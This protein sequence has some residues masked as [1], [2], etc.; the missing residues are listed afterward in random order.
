VSEVRRTGENLPLTEELSAVFARMSGLLL[1]EETVETS[2]GLLSSLAQE[3]VPGSSGAGVSI[4]DE[5][6]KRSS[7]STDARVRQ[8]DG[9][10]Y[11]LDE[12][13]C[14]AAAAGR[15]LVRIDDLAEDRRWPRWAAEVTTLGLRAAMS[16][17]LVAGNGSL[18]AIKVYADRPRT[19][20]H[21]SEQLLTLFSAQAAILVANVQTHDRAK[22][23][24]EGMREAFRGRDAVSVA[25]GVLMG[26]HSVDEDTAFAM[27]MSRAEQGGAPLVD[28]AQAVIDAAGRRRR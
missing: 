9:L 28:A 18:G 25:K 19:F 3:T 1:S 21:H 2:L 22:R 6:R 20:D 24:S 12:G 14:L 27:L 8:A 26:R 15:E 5:R 7:G 11:E 10:Q 17:P 16:A 4:I 23:L 13:P